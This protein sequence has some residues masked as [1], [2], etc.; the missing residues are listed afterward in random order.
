MYQYGCAGQLLEVESVASH[1]DHNDQH[2]VSTGLT[3]YQC[4]GWSEIPT[5]IYLTSPSSPIGNETVIK[6]L[7]WDIYFFYLEMTIK[8]SFDMNKRTATY[9]CASKPYMIWKQSY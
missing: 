3:T 9:L 7:E 6:W 4:N 5:T 8:Y 2:I 1:D